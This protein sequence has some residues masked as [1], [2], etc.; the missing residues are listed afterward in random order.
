MSPVDLVFLTL[1]LLF[2]IIGIVRGVARELGVTVMLLL[3]LMILELMGTMFL[4]QITQMLNQVFGMSPASVPDFLAMISIAVLI[5]FAFMSYQGVTLVYPIKSTNWFFSM[6]IGLING[7]L[8]AGSIWYYAQ[9]AGWPLLGSIIKPV[10]TEV[11]QNLIMLMP[12]AVFS[13]QVLL[14]FVVFLLILKV[15]K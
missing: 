9:T 4:P 14:L 13:W 12:P 10:Y 1:I 5:L 6:G 7:Y 8:L 15:W 2:G 11:N 3:A